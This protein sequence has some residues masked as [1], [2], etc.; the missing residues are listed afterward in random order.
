VRALEA[1]PEDDPRADRSAGLSTE[2]AR[3]R[4]E[5]E[6]PNEIVPPARRTW[7]ALSW[8]VK[9]VTDPMAL[10]LLIA[11][12]TYWL[13]GHDVDAIVT[14]VALVPITA[15][16]VA[17]EIRAERTLEALARLTAPQ[18]SVVRDGVDRT[19][20]ARDVVRGDRVLV[21]EGDVVPADGSLVDGTQLMLDESALTG[22]SEPVEKV[23]GHALFAGTTVLSGRGGLVVGATGSRTR[24]GQIVGLVAGAEE[25]RTPLQRVTARLVKWLSVVVLGLCAILVGAQVV[26]GHP[27]GEAVIAGVSL[28]IAAIPEEFPMVFSLFLALGAWRLARHDALIRRLPGVETLGST[29]VICADKT[30]TLTFGRL[31]VAG[32]AACGGDETALLEAAV[33]ACEP[34]PYDPLDRA[35]TTFAESRGVAVEALHGTS[36]LRDHPFDP[37]RRMLTHVWA[38][39]GGPRAAAKGALEGV[40]DACAAPAELRRWAKEQHD[41]FGEK[42]RRVIAVAAGPAAGEGSRQDDERR[43]E[44][45]GLVAFADP[46]RPGVPEALATCRAAGIRV[47]MI[48][49]DHP[50]TAHAVADALGL[51]HDDLQPVVTGDGLDRLSDGALEGVAQSC[52]IFARTR[53]DQKLRLVRALQRRG[54]V[55]AMT[56]DGV[57]DAPALR[58]ADI[59]VAMGAHG[60]EVARQAATMV[61][62]DDDFGTIVAAVHEGRRIF[63]SLKNAFGY[64][65]AFHV[66]LVIAACAV[67]L[68]GHPLFLLPIH[69][70]V[71]ELIVHPT[72][73]LVFENDPPPAS[74]MLRPPRTPTAGLLDRS[75]WRSV[76]VGLSLAIG[77]VAV[78]VG[79]VGGEER[80]RGLGFATLVL[81][82]MALVLTERSPDRPV[83]RSAPWSNGRLVP[84]LAL[85]LAGLVVVL[86]VAPVARVFRMAPLGA[87]DWVV[88]GSVAL[89]TTGWGEVLKLVRGSRARMSAP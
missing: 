84:I 67:P 76:A 69:L 61:L 40:L 48:T 29:T 1:R 81:G 65:V 86:S 72:V 26:A 60:T 32:V 85:T 34:D 39:P 49:G 63:S 4:L 73:A 70:L 44:L 12:P 7:R 37:D 19:V 27:L 42:A 59:G 20:Q 10:L 57:N 82:Q 87:E 5:R 2:E 78:Y 64:L 83:W 31:Q 3:R 62:L 43:L 68:L 36:L 17:L 22:E 25:S 79:A 75:S 21:R 30:G 54:E 58:E 53:P 13:L 55:V 9:A 15:V 45:V 46:V 35:I 71:L 47:L 74:L 77:T 80:A 24:Y 18:A 52:S 28:A 23:P 38:L 89:V 8:I 50:L 16:S 14:A 66:P 6:G 56:G 51:V 33:L 41:R 88:A 11:A